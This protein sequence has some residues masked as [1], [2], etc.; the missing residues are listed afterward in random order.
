[1]VDDFRARAIKAVDEKH[2]R[3]YFAATEKS[4]V[5]RQLYGVSLDT[6]DPG[7]SSASPGSRRARHHDVARDTHFYVDNFT[8]GSQPPQVSLHCADGNL[9]AYLLENRLD[10]SHP[11]APYLA[12][13]SV[14]EF[15][16]LP[17]ADGQ[18]L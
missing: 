18:L 10:A 13:N 9:M 16:A 7:A 11:D 14:P 15:G 2:R 6:K 1:M 3:I 4:P 12:D 5:E 8:S 17:A